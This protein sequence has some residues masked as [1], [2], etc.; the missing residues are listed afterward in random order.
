MKSKKKAAGL[1]IL[2]IQAVF[3]RVLLTYIDKWHGQLSVEHSWPDPHVWRAQKL[4][5]TWNTFKLN[6]KTFYWNGISTAWTAVTCGLWPSPAAAVETNGNTLTGSWWQKCLDGK[7]DLRN[8][9][10]TL[11]QC[12]QQFSGRKD[13]VPRPAC[14]YPILSAAAPLTK[15]SGSVAL[16]VVT[17]L[18]SPCPWE[19]SSAV[20]PSPSSAPVVP[21]GEKCH[22]FSPCPPCSG[23]QPTKNFALYNSAGMLK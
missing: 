5:V 14:S 19:S 8:L 15:R 12:L 6:H 9:L 16:F 18:C 4:R 20:W 11:R 2:G 7:M 1:L 23:E 10:F 3:I 21:P 22:G 13:A 17:L